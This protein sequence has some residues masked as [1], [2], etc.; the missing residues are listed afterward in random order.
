M[1]KRMIKVH[2]DAADPIM[3]TVCHVFVLYWGRIN[4]TRSR[5]LLIISRYRIITTLSCGLK[6]KIKENIYFKTVLN[7]CDHNCNK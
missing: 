2:C 5:S 4:I 3:H 1:A 6:G 7:N